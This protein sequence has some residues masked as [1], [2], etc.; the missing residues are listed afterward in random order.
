M[1]EHSTMI[2][3]TNGLS[4]NL[5][6][7]LIAERRLEGFV[8]YPPDSRNRRVPTEAEVTLSGAAL[9]GP[10]PERRT[11]GKILVSFRVDESDGGSGGATF[12]FASFAPLGQR[13][14]VV[15]QVTQAEPPA[16]PD[17]AVAWRAWEAVVFP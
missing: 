10:W 14:V 13:F 6:P 4:L 15:Q 5:P 11:V 12:T 9:G 3:H 2:T 8:I 1:N 17:F 16:R 7:T